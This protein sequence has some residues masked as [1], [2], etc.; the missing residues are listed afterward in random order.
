MENSLT[1]EQLEAAIGQGWQPI[2]PALGLTHLPTVTLAEEAVKRWFFGQA[3]ALA[4]WPPTP[5][6]GASLKQEQTDPIARVLDQSG[7]LLGVG[8]LTTGEAGP[9]LAPRVVLPAD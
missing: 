9:L 4:E 7:R 1:L 8:A 3:I 2:D 6:C 5:Q